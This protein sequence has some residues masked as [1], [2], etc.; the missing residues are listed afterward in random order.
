MTTSPSPYDSSGWDD[1]YWAYRA[2]CI[3]GKWGCGQLGQH[4]QIAIMCHHSDDYFE[5]TG[6]YY[7]IDE[8]EVEVVD[9]NRQRALEQLLEN[10]PE[11]RRTPKPA[12]AR[13]PSP[14]S[15]IDASAETKAAK[16]EPTPSNNPALAAILPDILA[17]PKLCPTPL[18]EPS[19][20]HLYIL[21]ILHPNNHRQLK[22]TPPPTTTPPAK[23]APAH[24]EKCRGAGE[25]PTTAK[26]ATVAQAEGDTCQ[27]VSANDP[28]YDVKD[29]N[30]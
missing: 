6:E 17:E 20:R 28:S 3:S 13:S 7:M 21:Q 12:P 11:L 4:S 19:Q 29:T 8:E 27:R 14:T 10:P 9:W 1:A 30:E 18:L 24:P 26:V 25:A 16:P 23:Q 22:A 2:D 5:R 15:V